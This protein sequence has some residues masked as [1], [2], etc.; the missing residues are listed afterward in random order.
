MAQN[1]GESDD[2]NNQ[3]STKDEYFSHNAT[4]DDDNFSISLTAQL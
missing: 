4:L 1:A 3:N 2:N